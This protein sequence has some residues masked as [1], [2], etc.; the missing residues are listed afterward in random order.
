VRAKIY[1]ALFALAFAIVFGSASIHLAIAEG[2]QPCDSRSAGLAED[3]SDNLS[4]SRPGEVVL[5]YLDL[6]GLSTG[7]GFSD[8]PTRRWVFVAHGAIQA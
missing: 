6:P 4:G 5:S 8:N 3:L 7:W 2:L 1:N